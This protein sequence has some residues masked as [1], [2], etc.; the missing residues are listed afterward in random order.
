MIQEVRDMAAHLHADYPETWRALGTSRDLYTG[1]NSLGVRLIIAFGEA[2]F[3]DRD[4]RLLCLQQTFGREFMTSKQLTVGE[5]R[6]LLAYANEFEDIF[7][8]IG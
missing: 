3:S 8:G 6:A 5:A 4:T 2:G 7:N 1:A